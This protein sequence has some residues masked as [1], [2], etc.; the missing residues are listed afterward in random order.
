MPK[1]SLLDMTQN[2][3]SDMDSDAVNSI[4]DTDEASQVAS[5][6][7]ET[8]YFLIDNR[9]IPEHEGLIQL[10]ALGDVDTPSHMKAPD[11]QHEIAWIKYNVVQS[12]GTSPDW[13]EMIFKEPLEFLDIINS[14]NSSDSNIEAVAD[15]TSSSTLLIENDKAPTYWTSF[16]DEYIVFDSYDSV[17][18]SSLQQSKTMAYGKE[19][20]TWTASDNFTP[21]L[22]SNLFSL[23]LNEAKSQAF[24]TLKQVTNSKSEQRSR[25]Q[26]T[27]QQK[28]QNRFSEKGNLHDRQPNY[29]RK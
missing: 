19:E 12:G 18:E 13:A 26:R 28:Y 3:L 16:D 8:Y 24:I 21:D 17:V 6:I 7:K 22:D 11:N 5:I 2:I 9:K 27:L 14:R 10:T 1:M 15:I 23:L 25:K 4:S 29:G 20:P